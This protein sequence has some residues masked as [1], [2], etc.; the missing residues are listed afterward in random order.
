[1][2]DALNVL[3]E[4]GS[5]IFFSRVRPVPPEPAANREGLPGRNSST[6]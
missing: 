1:V 6:R 2:E 4:D 5:D 3:S